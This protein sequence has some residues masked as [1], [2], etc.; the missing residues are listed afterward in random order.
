MSNLP[1]LLSQIDTVLKTSRS[2]D[3]DHEAFYSQLSHAVMRLDAA[4]WRNPPMTRA[5]AALDYLPTLTA[6][7]AKVNCNSKRIPPESK[8]DPQILCQGHIASSVSNIVFMLSNTTDLS[9]YTNRSVALIPALIET[10]RKYPN[11]GPISSSSTEFYG[12]EGR[13]RS[14]R[15]NIHKTSVHVWEAVTVATNASIKTTGEYVDILTQ[16]ETLVAFYKTVT[17]LMKE[18]SM[19]GDMPTILRAL[20][21][22][23]G[24][25]VAHCA[26]YVRTAVSNKEFDM[27]ILFDY[28][29]KIGYRDA[30]IAED[31]CYLCEV[32]T[33]HA[34]HVATIQ[35]IRA[36]SKCMR[37]HVPINNPAVLACK[38]ASAVLINSTYLIPR[39]DFNQAV[40]EYG[41]IELIVRNIDM[42]A[43]KMH[44][45]QVVLLLERC[46]WL[47]SRFSE[48]SSM[49]Q[50]LL[51]HG[52]GHSV[53]N[54]KGKV[55]HPVLIKWVNS[56]NL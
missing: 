53:R 5:F 43:E 29:E 45:E 10:Q 49:R 38:R 40:M 20:A 36:A 25:A 52:V 32:I 55:T 56:I 31:C 33:K 23:I 47:V 24:M 9:G 35:L 28:M 42:T 44:N 34:P 50:E 1:S 46:L 6:V 4:L 19:A 16:P 41:I 18:E 21:D 39:Q 30:Y 54:L 26:A 15:N 11:Y 12:E 2:F 22:T 48:S 14:I 7:L 17:T 37:Q 3:Y 13:F 27:S 8:R 51:R